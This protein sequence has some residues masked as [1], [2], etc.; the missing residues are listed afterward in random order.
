MTVSCC[1]ATVT[2]MLERFAVLASSMRAR[3]Y[4]LK[5]RTSCSVYRFGGRERLL[6]ILLFA[7]VTAVF[8]GTALGM[9]NALYDPQIAVAPLSPVRI[10][11]CAVYA[12]MMVFPVWGMRST[13]A[14]L[15]TQP[16]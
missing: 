11:F 5:G 15:P 1:F 7:L 12:A 14:Y 10:I 8:S 13:A 3:G 6:V 9:T 4:G 16:L 2:Q